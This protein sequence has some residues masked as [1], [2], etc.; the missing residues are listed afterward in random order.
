MQET[1]KIRNGK[2]FFYLLHSSVFSEFHKCMYIFKFYLGDGTNN[3]KCPTTSGNVCS[4]VKYHKDVQ[5]L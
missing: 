4:Q 3:D 1:L 2:I 5:C